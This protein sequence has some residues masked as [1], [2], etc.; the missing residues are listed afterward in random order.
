MMRDL[1]EI[2]ASS[3][4]FTQCSA[5]IFTAASSTSL[6]LF[7]KISK[8]FRCFD[9]MVSIIW[10]PIFWQPSAERK[11]MSD[12][13]VR[14][15]DIP[16]SVISEQFST[17]RT[18]CD[19]VSWRSKRKEWVY[20]YSV[21]PY[22]CSQVRIRTRHQHGRYLV[23]RISMVKPTYPIFISKWY[24]Y[25]QESKLWVWCSLPPR[26]EVPFS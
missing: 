2:N 23:V 5:N 22:S 8:R 17:P 20:T 15:R 21:Y 19:I 6:H 13:P 26:N 25:F 14:Q 11:C 3:I 16:S 9:A 7:T 18:S 1:I 4:T 12:R 10:Y 24:D